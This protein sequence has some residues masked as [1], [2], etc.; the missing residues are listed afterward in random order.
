MC[1]WKLHTSPVRVSISLLV[2]SVS[3]HFL[4]LDSMD[5]WVC[6]FCDTVEKR[7]VSRRKGLTSCS[8]SLLTLGCLLLSFALNQFWCPS[9]HKDELASS[10]KWQISIPTRKK[11]KSDF[12]FPLLINWIISPCNLT[13]KLAI[14]GSKEL[15]AP[16]RLLS[17]FG[18]L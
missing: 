14:G 2:C 16:D 10:L 8:L 15:R 11:G 6:G 1:Q 3:A 4:V 13:N 18:C 12:F 9:Y 5:M 17:A 7:M